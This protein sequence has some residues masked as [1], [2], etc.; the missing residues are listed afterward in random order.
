MTSLFV[1][2]I[3]LLFFGGLALSLIGLLALRHSSGPRSGTSSDEPPT[4]D[5]QELTFEGGMLVD[6]CPRAR[7]ALSHE[8]LEDGPLTR[9]SERLADIFPGFTHSFAAAQS[10]NA[11]FELSDVTTDGPI[12][13][14]VD[15]QPN[16]TQFAVTG[17]P[18]LLARKV[19]VDRAV[20]DA[21]ERELTVLRNTVSTSPAVIWRESSMGE[22]D[23][24]NSAYLELAEGV[25]PDDNTLWPPKRLF[26]GA[27][28]TPPGETPHARRAPLTLQDGTTRWFDITSHGH[29]NTTLH[30]ACDSSKTVQAEET[31]RNFM[32]TLTQTFAALPVGLAIFDRSRQLQLFNPALMELTTLEP[33]WLAARPTLYDVI[34]RMREKRMLPERKDFKDWRRKL[35]ELENSAVNGTYL[36]TWVLPTGQTYK[37]T[38]RPHPEGAVAFLIEDISAEISL[39]RKFRRELEVS[40]SLLDNLPQAIAVFDAAGNLTLSNEAYCT[41]WGTDPELVL[42]QTNIVE[43]SSHWQAKS[44]PTPLW[45]DVREFVCH[46]GERAEWHGSA[47]LEDGRQLACQFMPLAG[48]ATL[49]SF[50]EPDGVSDP[51]PE[52][53]RL[54]T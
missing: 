37:V 17:L 5:L 24:V 28:I 34:N 42:Q 22:I 3:P 21:N 33:E 44:L 43:A 7:A 1:Q 27:S 53:T 15:C 47:D 48:G 20:T 19:L 35:V 25:D 36:E 49:V 16:R 29:G 32:Q 4:T 54:T 41:L 18:H 40:Q 10:E 51:L 23:W 31:L 46:A 26:D 11:R 12:S 2:P 38:G 9:L 14:K 8:D 50:E 6:A 39:T 45:G 30:Y 52:L 13:V